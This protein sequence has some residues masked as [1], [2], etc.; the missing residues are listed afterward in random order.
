[1]KK[2]TKF[3]HLHVSDLWLVLRATVLYAMSL[4]AIRLVGKRTIG[5]LSPFD[6]LVIVILGAAVAIPM[7][8]EKLPFTHGLIPIVM[9]TL[10]SWLISK[11]ILRSRRIENV[12]QGKPCV[13]IE[14]GEVVV[15]NIKQE[16]ISMTDLAIMLREK[17]V[18][19]IQDVQEAVLEPNGLLSVI[20]KP[21][22][23]PLRPKDI[24]ISTTEGIYPTVL[25]MNGEVIYDN[26]DRVRLGLPQLMR[27]LAERGIRRVQEVRSATLDETGQV[28][29]QLEEGG[30]R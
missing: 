17:D 13:L 6:L 27:E 14:N 28:T 5:Q 11:V 20:L 30:E 23:Q 18:N 26:L 19:N 29:V 2:I 8:D 9:V 22:C 25:V 3:L 10:I 1:M 24:G 12:L 7:E 15:K 4:L 16:R 21:E